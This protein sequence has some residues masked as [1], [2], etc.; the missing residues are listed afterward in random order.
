MLR[1]CA[2][3]YESRT[4]DSIRRAAHSKK[5]VDD[6]TRT[7]VVSDLSSKRIIGEVSTIDGLDCNETS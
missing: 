6:V 3:L 1:R 5:T 2:C 4:R 7:D